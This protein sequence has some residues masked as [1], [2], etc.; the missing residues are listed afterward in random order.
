MVAMT[1]EIRERSE[2]RARSETR[3]RP[4]A[5]PRFNMNSL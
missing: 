3:L 5:N 4:L 1:S 2:I